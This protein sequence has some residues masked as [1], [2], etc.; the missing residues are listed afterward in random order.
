MNTKK[1]VNAALCVLV[2]EFV[3][4]AG[5]VFAFPAISGWYQI[6][7]KPAFTPPSWAFGPIWLVMYALMGIALSLVWETHTKTKQMGKQTALFTLQLVLNFLWSFLFFGLRSIALGLIEIVALWIAVLATTIEFYKVSK[8]AA[9]LM[10]PYLAW[11]TVAMLL[12]LYVLKLNP[13]P[14]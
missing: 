1:L 8:K 10:M 7:Q 12:N 2:C 9:A 4:A 5:S 14:L 3:G 6:L 13:S 11:V